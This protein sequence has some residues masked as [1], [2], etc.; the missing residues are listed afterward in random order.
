M[1]HEASQDNLASK[2]RESHLS[3]DE[4]NYINPFSHK[5][6]AEKIDIASRK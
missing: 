3:D 2:R 1:P 5:A 4:S 6:M